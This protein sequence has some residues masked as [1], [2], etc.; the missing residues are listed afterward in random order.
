MSHQPRGLGDLGGSSRGKSMGEVRR[1]KVNMPPRAAVGALL[2]TDAALTERRLFSSRKSHARLSGN[3]RCQT[4]R[5]TPPRYS[6]FY[7]LS[8]FPDRA[9]RSRHQPHRFTPPTVPRDK[10][11]RPPGPT[12]RSSSPKDGRSFAAYSP[13]T[14]RASRSSLLPSGQTRWRRSHRRRCRYTSPTRRCL[15]A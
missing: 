1:V 8:S 6:I 3:P 13:A 4:G 2:T 15:T 10:G 12:G 7:L 11:P 9:P 14:F 5:S